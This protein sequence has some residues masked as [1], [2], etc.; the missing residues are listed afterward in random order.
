MKGL[1][2]KKVAAIGIG[3]A[4]VGSALA[5]VVS[6]A[7]VVDGG[8]DD[9]AKED[10]VSATGMPVVDVVVGSNAAVSDVVWAGN[11][12]ARV[13]QLATVGGEEAANDSTVDVT[14]GG[15]TSVTGE[16]EEEDI[17][18][19]NGVAAIGLVADDGDT[20]VL[21]DD[22]V[23]W[24]Q[25][26]DSQDDIDVDEI[27]YTNSSNLYSSLQTDGDGVLAGQMVV[28]A[29]SNA[30]GYMVLFDAPIVPFG[31]N[32]DIDLEV[33]FLGQMWDVASADLDEIVLKS[34]ELSEKILIGDSITVNGIGDYEGQELQL[35]LTDVVVAG[36]NDEDFEAEFE[37]RDGDTVIEVVTEVQDNDDLQ[38]EIEDYTDTALF[39]DTVRQSIDA[40]QSFVRVNTGDQQLNLQDGEEL[41]ED[42]NDDADKWIVKIHED[43]GDIAGISIYNSP[44]FT[45]K[46]SHADDDDLEGEDEDAYKMGP[47]AI[48]TEINIADRGLYK[49][50]ALGLT[51]E[52]MYYNKIGEETLYLSVD[53]K[54]QE[55]PLVIGPY[56]NGQEIK[57]EVLGED[58]VIYLNDDANVLK[59]FENSELTDDAEDEVADQSYSFVAAKAAADFNDSVSFTLGAGDIGVD[60][61]LVGFWEDDDVTFMLSLTAQDLNGDVDLTLDGTYADKNDGD[62]TIVPYYLP[63]DLPDE[64]FDNWAGTD[65][66]VLEDDDED[67]YAA[68]FTLSDGNTD[69]YMKARVDTST[70]NLIDTSDD[71]ANI[72]STDPQ[73]SLVTPVATVDLDAS[74]DD[75]LVTAGTDWGTEISVEDSMLAWNVPDQRR[76]LMV[77]LGSF[78]TTE[79]VS[80]GTVFEDLMNDESETKE[81]ITVTV[82]GM[83][84]ATAGVQVV[85]VDDLVKLDTESSNGRSIIVGGWVANAAARNLEVTEGNTLEDLLLNDGDYVAAVLASGDIVAAGFNAMDTADAASD[86]IDALEGLM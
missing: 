66:N 42:G 41:D 26:G 50:S 76:D 28:N 3:A 60:Y 21:Y 54:M 55:V 71:Y 73:V 29:D 83:S 36:D 45:Y 80:G 84:G 6:A 81:G 62:T 24:D 5:P 58:Y 85:P 46:I 53:E 32:E 74:E 33:P 16:G 59:V 11:I 17:R 64:I 30:F 35:V 7:N 25:N 57:V 43:S 68:I 86:L 56:D 79:T 22:S 48:G 27:L 44:D 14:I 12:A 8:L 19:Q 34:N 82:N 70:G 38:S 69:I 49:F 78:E 77:Y 37:L 1:N 67:K 52:D 2:I 47:M 13:A 39:V 23:D 75:E 40:Q 63:T 72:G 4:L 18:F 61:T 15:S 10:V 20:D 9:L 65:G 31:I 51:T